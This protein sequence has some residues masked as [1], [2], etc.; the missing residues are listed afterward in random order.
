MTVSVRIEGETIH[1]K[2]DMDLAH[3]DG[4]GVGLLAF[5]EPLNTYRAATIQLVNSVGS[6]S[7]AVDGS[8]SGTPDVV[9]LD[10]PTT[11]WTNTAISGTWD[12]ASTTITPQGGTESID[13]TATVD[14]S[15]FQIEKSSTVDLSS[16][17]AI[18]GHVYLTSWNAAKHEICV[19]LRLAGV[20][21][22]VEL[23]LASFIDEGALNAWQQFVIPLDDLGAASATIDQFVFTTKSS[24]GQPPN[25]YLDTINIE[26]A[27]TEIFGFAPP[28][29]MVFDI[30]S[31]SLV[32]RDDITVLEPN[33][34]MGLAAL[35]NGLRIRTVSEKV[36]RFSAGIHTIYDFESFGGIKVSETIG[37]T[38]MMVSFKATGQPSRLVGDKGDVY[39]WVVSDD[40]TGVTDIKVVV[41][42]RIQDARA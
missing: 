38:E 31:V 40:L 9:Y 19:E 22:G 3:K 20:T 29:G 8:I 12:F 11:N 16:Y 35:Q 17:A 24:S 37:A 4:E 33:Q 6:T 36:T 7:L 30:F 14:G 26:E 27:G 28:P 5:T 10:E 13:A 41:K 32:M 1:G 42:G 34:M 2:S 15:S 23:N 18:S 25:Y 21:Q 39:S